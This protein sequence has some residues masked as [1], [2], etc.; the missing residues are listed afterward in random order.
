[1]PDIRQY[2]SR[3]HVMRKVAIGEYNGFTREIVLETVDRF[4]SCGQTLHDKP[5]LYSSLENEMRV[6]FLVRKNGVAVVWTPGWGID[7]HWSPGTE[8]DFLDGVDSRDECPFVD[9]PCKSDGSSLAD[10]DQAWPA[11]RQ[12]MEDVWLLLQGWWRNNVE[13][14]A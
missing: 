14:D 7:I 10:G 11:F 4:R 1:M 8:P 12:G 9:G 5:E 3:N 2:R 6:R 13:E